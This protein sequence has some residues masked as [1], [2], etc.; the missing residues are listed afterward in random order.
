MS[1]S[2]TDLYMW[3]E[4]LSW[5]AKS[6]QTKYQNLEEAGDNEMALAWHESFRKTTNSVIAVAMVVLKVEEIVKNKTRSITT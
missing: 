5:M 6:A 2:W 3:G 4:K 1:R